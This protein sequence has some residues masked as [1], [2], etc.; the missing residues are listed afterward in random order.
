MVQPDFYRNMQVAVAA[1]SIVDGTYTRI[2]LDKYAADL[3][4]SARCHRIRSLDPSD[5]KV[6]VLPTPQEILRQFHCA[7]RSVTVLFACN[8]ID[9]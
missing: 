8:R 6:S 3:S 7:L 9:V 1:R 2:T 5:N 4:A